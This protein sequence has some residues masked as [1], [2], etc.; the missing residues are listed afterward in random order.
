MN[1][2]LPPREDAVRFI[3]DR[4]SM[5]RVMRGSVWAEYYIAALDEIE[6][7]KLKIERRRPRRKMNL[8]EAER[9]RRRQHGRWLAERRKASQ[10]TD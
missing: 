3:N 8:S 5:G 6:A 10:P 2:P 9:E 1:R 7:L 4:D